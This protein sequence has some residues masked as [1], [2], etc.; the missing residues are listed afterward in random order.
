M[1]Q[2]VKPLTWLFGVAFVAIGIIGFVNNPVAG[3][4]QVDT[5][6][7]LVLLVSGLAALAAAATSYRASRLLLMLF[8]VIYGL[9]TVL[10]FLSADGIILHLLTVNPADTYLHLVIAVISLVAGFG[11]PVAT[12][13]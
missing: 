3:L 12:T 10:G 5:V 11:S 8:G 4:F 9:A 7:S 13:V 6:Q 2:A 1:P